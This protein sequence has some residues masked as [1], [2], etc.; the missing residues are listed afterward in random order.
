MDFP[1][2][3]TKT[4]IRAFL[5][6]AGYYAHYMKNFSLIAAPLTH[7]LKGKIKKEWVTWTKECDQA[8][9]KLKTRL[10]EMPVL[11]AP[12]YKREFIIQT[13]ASDLG[14]GIVM[15][16]H[17]EENEEHPV[18]YLSKKFTDA[19]RKHG[20]IGKKCA[21]INY[22]IK[23]LKYYLEGQNFTTETDHNPL[24]RLK[25][26]AG[27][28][29]HLMRWSLALQPFQYKVIHKAGKK[30]LNADALSRSDIE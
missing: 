29:P 13:D 19:Q 12:V 3:T 30:H 2:P 16:Q 11:Y 14:I 4:Q 23:K 8:I 22:A 27:T 26:N 18:L 21:A 25:A 15:S 17:D 20:T 6:L 9:N 24:V 1:I 5:G 28:N 7:V 10:T